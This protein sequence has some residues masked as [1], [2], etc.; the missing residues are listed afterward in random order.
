MKDYEYKHPFKF[1]H[2]VVFDFYISINFKYK[3]K[4]EMD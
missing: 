4:T 2:N 3:N 1:F